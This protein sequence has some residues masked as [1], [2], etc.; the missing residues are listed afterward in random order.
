MNRTNGLSIVDKEHIRQSVGDILTT[1]IGS[2]VMRRSYGSLVPELIDHPDNQVTQI[3]LF[4]AVASSLMRWEPRMRLTR[5]RIARER[6]GR[7]DITLECVNLADS[8][9]PQPLMLQVPVVLRQGA[10]A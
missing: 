5:I 6:A 8:R 10:G 2:R 9:T 3:R 1:P 7:A 4:A